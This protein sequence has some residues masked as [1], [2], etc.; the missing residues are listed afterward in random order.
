MP[1]IVL[2]MS[3]LNT[4]SRYRGIGRYAKELGKALSLAATQGLDL[5]ALTHFGSDHERCLASSLAYSGNEALTPTREMDHRVAHARTRML[6][7]IARSVGA[8]AVHLL[9]PSPLID[10]RALLSVVTCHDIIP[11]ALASEYYG[12]RP[13]RRW[14]ERRRLQQAFAHADRCIAVSHTTKSDLIRLC[15]FDPARVDVVY[16]GIDHSLFRVADREQA[17]ESVRVT[18]GLDRPYLVYV[19]GAD[20]RRR[21]PNLIRA[22]DSSRVAKEF[23][24]VLIGSEH[25]LSLEVS[26]A[27]RE[28]RHGKV[29]L[30]GYVPDDFLGAVYRAAHAHVFPSIYEG[31]G[32]PVLESMACGTPTL[33]CQRTALAELAAE[34]ALGFEADE[35]DALR[36]GIERICLD[37]TLRALLTVKGPKVAQAFTWERAAKETLEVYKRVLESV[38]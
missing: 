37:E 21:V 36:S 29:Q 35:L 26:Q 7:K 24:L 34:G 31:F 13:L 14:R 22:Y 19:G 6:A 25:S 28:V 18:L 10:Q 30:L 8:R 9:D 32:F 20:V 4:L 12:R 33:V 3:C 15:G 11:I 17:R 27:V 1:D 5:A 16:H 38:H 23:T 2:D